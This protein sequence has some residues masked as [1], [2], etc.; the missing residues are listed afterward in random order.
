[1]D[2]VL[3]GALTVAILTGA[4]LILLLIEPDVPARGR[5]AGGSSDPLDE[6]AASPAVMHGRADPTVSSGAVASPGDSRGDGPE[7]TVRNG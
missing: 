5:V 6:S 1:M 2:W 3:L 4:A 7:H